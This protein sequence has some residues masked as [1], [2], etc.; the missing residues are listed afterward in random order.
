MIDDGY[1]IAIDRPAPFAIPSPQAAREAMVADEIAISVRA[2]SPLSRTEAERLIAR[3]LAT[4]EAVKRE[5]PAPWTPSAPT[6]E[7]SAEIRAERRA[8]RAEALATADASQPAMIDARPSA[9]LQA[10]SLP[11]DRWSLAKGRLRALLKGYGTHPNPDIAAASCDQP[12]LAAEI[13]ILMHAAA[14]T[15]KRRQTGRWGKPPRYERTNPFWG[16]SRADFGRVLQRLA[17]NI[18]DRSTSMPGYGP[19]HVPK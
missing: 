4:Y 10:T 17:E 9:V 3:D 12:K 16:V 5:A 1:T 18:C 14:R 6:A 15:Q 8:Q 13:V 11:T 7:E 2:G 19:W